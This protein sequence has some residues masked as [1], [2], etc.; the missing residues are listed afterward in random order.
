VQL[1]GRTDGDLIVVF[2]CPPGRSPDSII[3]AIHPVRIT[4][5]NVLTMFGELRG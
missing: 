3:G 2:D 5:A 4:G 1:T